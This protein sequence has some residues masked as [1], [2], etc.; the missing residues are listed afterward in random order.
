MHAWLWHSWGG[1]PPEITE[2]AAPL[3]G[4]PVFWPFV[5]LLV[6]A[7]GCLAATQQ[8]RDWTQIVILALV[9]WQ[10][11]ASPATHRVLRA[12]VRLLA[13]GA[14][15]LGASCGCGPIAIGGCRHAAAAV[16]ARGDGRRHARGHL[17]QSY[18][19]S[20][21]L[22]DLPVLRSQYP[23]D[24]LQ[25]MVDHRL[26]GKT[27]V[28]F[29]WAQYA[30]GGAVARGDCRLRRPV[31][32]LLSAGG[33]RHALRFAAGRHGPAQPPSPTPGPIDGTRV[34]EYGQPDLVLLERRYKNC[35]A[36]MQAEARER[37]PSGRCSTATPWRNCGAV[38]RGTTTRQAR[39]TSRWRAGG[40]T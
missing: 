9:A 6:V 33:D 37:T 11:C 8:Q 12:A 35:V 4:K 26:G 19:L 34:L 1:A 20:M 2:W 7:V 22:S 25:Y 13:A 38:R 39:T 31:R 5:T 32:H 23:V 10:A 17:V 24:A 16:A 3:P 29:N 36:V 15:A 28:A 14:L 30:A 40:S 27:V 21:R 18:A